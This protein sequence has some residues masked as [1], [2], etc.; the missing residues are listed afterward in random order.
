MKTKKPTKGDL[1]FYKRTEEAWKR[2]EKGEFI[3]MDVKKFLKM[4][5]KL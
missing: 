3:R 2:Y 4:L 5:K 1:I